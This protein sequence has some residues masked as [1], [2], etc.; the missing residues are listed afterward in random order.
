[1]Y[2]I[3]FDDSEWRKKIISDGPK[4]FN[5]AISQSEGP[6]PHSTLKFES[7]VNFWAM[8]SYLFLIPI[9]L[10]GNEITVCE[11]EMEML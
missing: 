1:M 9:R 6:R 7:A 11:N 3:E 8:P 4:V 10:I 2:S 5:Y